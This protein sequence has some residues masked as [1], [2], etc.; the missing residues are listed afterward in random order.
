[1]IPK[2]EDCKPGL[3]PMGYNVLVALDVIE[4]RIGNIIIPDQHKDR[5]NS[6]SEKGRVVS[7]SPMAF[8][9]GD[10]AGV[11]DDT[12]VAAG[13]VTVVAAAASAGAAAGVTGS[14]GSSA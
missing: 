1:M 11:S 14:A 12:G 6:K 9:G 8:S 10:F 5:E 4:D 3:K 13:G 7:L 2:I